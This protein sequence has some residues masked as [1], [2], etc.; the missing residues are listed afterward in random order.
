MPSVPR[1]ALL[2]SAAAALLALLPAATATADP[3]PF[4][5]ACTPQNGVRFCPTTDLSSRP[6]S[7]DGTPLDV[8]VTL[9][10]TGDGP[11]PTIL[12]LHGLGGDKTSFES[13]AGDKS[14]NNWFFA[15]QG[16][17][18]VT[19]TARGFG[20]S[21]GKLE[22][23]TPSCA[24]GWTRLGDM[25]YEVRDIQTLVGQLVDQGVVKPDAIG[26]TGISFGG[27]FSTMLAF[28]K[29]RVRLPDGSY[30]PW[31]SPKGTPISLTAAWPRWLWSNGESIF[32][33]NGRGPWSRTP[34]GVEA[35][36][37]A[38]GIFAVAL[39]GFT[40][41]TGGD[42]ST[43]LTKWKAQLDS[44]KLGAAVQPTLDN[45]Y[46]YH[47]VAGMS[48][49][50]TPLL[51]QSGWTD[52]LFPVGQSLGAYDHI[53]AQSKTAPVALQVADLGHDP[54]ANHPKD[55]AAF[56]RQGLAFFD[57]W[58]KGSGG[59]KPAPGSVTAYTTTCPKTAASGGGPFKAS[60]FGALA[61]ST[62]RF[63]T[64]K[65]LKIT[66]KG[67]NAKLAAELSPL[68]GAMGT[69]C[70]THT[71]DKASHATLSTTARGQTL[72][73]QPVITGRAVVKGRYGQ[74][75]ARVWDQDPATGKVKLVD[76]GAYRLTDD[77]TGSFRFTLDG[78]GW[79]FPKGH[80]IVVELLGRDAPTYGPSP[81]TFSATLTKVK[82]AL[83]IR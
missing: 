6:T 36:A 77:F 48:G 45:S 21:C 51:L 56:D 69:H 1:S 75:D 81:A 80:K 70:A 43:D 27:G 38:A 54:G 61:T 28:L 57:A 18:V 5:H 67:G 3:T 31:T 20:D 37:Y 41:P 30:A 22:S 76:R 42:L 10:S 47:G 33:R 74:L 35:Q 17:A 39:S 29:D 4:G 9:P 83:P 68:A 50:P 44:G 49:P 12:L 23:R 14:Y 11:F 52:A 7:F 79:K 78:N 73:G 65:A 72:I 32:T 2:A 13:T 15:Q 46:K 66:S 62:L 53:R 24:T 40:A 16:Y 34:T 55:V 26:S 58:V 63:G 64:S 19:P 82:V 60:S 71:P 59:S 25:R 8:D